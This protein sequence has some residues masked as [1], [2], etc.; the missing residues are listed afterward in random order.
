MSKNGDHDAFD[1]CVPTRGKGGNGTTKDAEE[2]G[3]TG[4][5]RIIG[6]GVGMRRGMTFGRRLG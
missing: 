5:K 4:G 6:V 3:S 1:L 2:L